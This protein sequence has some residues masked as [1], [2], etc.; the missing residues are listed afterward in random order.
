[1]GPATDKF[2]R[3]IDY[4]RISVTDRCNLR[5]IYCVPR[6]GVRPFDQETLLKCEEITR[7]AKI[8]AGLGLRKVRI[9]GGEPLVRKDLPLL[10]ESLSALDGIEDI[11]LTTNGL[12]LKQ[13]ARAL[14]S[15]GLK[16]V[17][18]SLDSLHRDRCR[19]ITR[20][21]EMYDVLNGI[22]EAQTAGLLPGK[23]NM[24]PM[25]GINDDEIE[26]FALLTRDTPLHVRFIELMP[27]GSGEFRSRGCSIATGEIRQRVSRIGVCRPSGRESPDR[28]DISGSKTLR[29]SSGSSAP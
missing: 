19:Q 8:A 9:T 21:G 2:G 27:A 3:V 15:A 24:I 16:R 5:C 23:I 14:A 10:I 6:G 18:V 11:S 12:L 22:A 1:M 28:P 25:R 29:A 4:L 7:V 13:S 26:E 20:G 17:N